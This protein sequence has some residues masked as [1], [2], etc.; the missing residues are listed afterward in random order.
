MKTDGAGRLFLG[1]LDHFAALVFAAMGADSMGELRLMA[2]GALGQNGP[3]QRIVRA[4][5]RRTAFGV[6]SFGIWHF[7]NYSFFLAA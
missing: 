7:L 4:A 3:A 5:R 2:I 1:D 6:S